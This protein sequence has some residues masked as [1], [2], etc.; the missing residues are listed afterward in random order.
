MKV[1]KLDEFGNPICDENGKQIWEEKTIDFTAKLVPPHKKKS[2]EV[3]EKD[4]P[5][6]IAD[7]HILYNL[8]YTQ[9]G[10]IPGCF[11]VHHSQIENKHPLNFF[12]TADKEV[13]INPV[14]VKHTKVPVDRVEGCLTFPMNPPTKVKRF[15]KIEVE[16][17]LLTKDGKI[18]PVISRSFSGVDAQVYQHEIQ[19]SKGSYIYDIK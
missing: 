15:N 8:C 9:V 5:R 10:Y 14:I 6:V 18:G 16:L 2:K 3:T 13:I 7:A 17:Q 12:V 4:L 19:H 11:A 1:K